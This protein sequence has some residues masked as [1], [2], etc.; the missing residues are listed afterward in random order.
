MQTAYSTQPLTNTEKLEKL[1]RI[2]QQYRKE[3][4]KLG[5]K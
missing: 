5:Q 1:K 4:D 2:E 3:Q